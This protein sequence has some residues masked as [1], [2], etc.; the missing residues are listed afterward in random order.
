MLGGH[1]TLL[2]AGLGWLVRTG[3]VLG[4]ATGAMHRASAVPAFVEPAAIRV[5][6]GPDLGAFDPHA[7]ASSYRVRPDS[8]RAGTRLAGA[9]IPRAAGYV[10]RTPP[11]V[12]GAIEVLGDGQPIV[13]GPEHRSSAWWPARMLVRDQVAA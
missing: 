4:V 8:D 5:L 3:D 1:G 7:L 6:P 10:E 2:C 11:L 9:A 13:L 12:R